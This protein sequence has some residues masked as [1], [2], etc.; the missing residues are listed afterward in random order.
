MQIGCRGLH[1]AG[2]DVDDCGFMLN[3]CSCLVF[4]NTGF[5]VTVLQMVPWAG[6]VCHPRSSCI[7]WCPE[8]VFSALRAYASSGGGKILGV[9]V[10]VLS[11]APVGV[12]LV[13]KNH[14]MFCE[15]QNTNH[16]SRQVQ[17][18]FHSSGVNYPPFGC[19]GTYTTTEALNLRYSLST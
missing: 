4:Q 1:H 9:L 19:L 7:V 18:G 3:L 13:R 5:A 12:N 2:F 10:F 16:L 11:L 14:A 17:Y 6:T 15:I 8:I